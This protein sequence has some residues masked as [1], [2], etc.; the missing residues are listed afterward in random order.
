[1][2]RDEPRPPS[3]RQLKVGEELRHAIAE[4]LIRGELH[5]PELENYSV[6]VS[7]VKISPDLKNALA[8]I[9]P[10]AGTD[11]EKV[12]KLLNDAAPH[13]RHLVSKKV[14]LRAVPRIKFILDHSFEN[15][16]RINRILQKDEVKR[17]TEN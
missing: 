1:M 12:A 3:S 13:V 11:K 9:M 14:Y 4:I 17:D 10:L 15:A 2:S 7:E 6:T 8:F 16:E 5:T